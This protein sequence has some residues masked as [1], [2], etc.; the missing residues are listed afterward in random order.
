MYLSARINRRKCFAN[1]GLRV[2]HMDIASPFFVVPVIVAVFFTCILWATS[3]NPDSHQP[4]ES[5]AGH[6]PPAGHH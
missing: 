3:G 6:M 2:D 1:L 5:S 4:T